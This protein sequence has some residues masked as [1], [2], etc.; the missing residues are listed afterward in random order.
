MNDR[1]F[2]FKH[3]SKQLTFTGRSR[4]AD[5]TALFCPELSLGLDAGENFFGSL[6]THA[7]VVFTHCHAD[8]SFGAS[9]CVSRRRQPRFFIPISQAQLLDAFLLNSQQLTNGAVFADPTVDY[10]CNHVT[11]GVQAGE[12]HDLSATVSFQVFE[13]VHSVP[14]V[15]YGFFERKKRLSP[16][17]AGLS[18]P[19]IAALR[20]SGVDVTHTVNDKLFAFLGDTTHA[21]LINNPELLEFPVVIVECS[22]IDDVDVE[23]A[24]KT[25]HMHWQHLKPIVQAHAATTFVL[26][27]FSLRYN[28]A[29][30]H[31]F[32]EAEAMPNVVVFLAK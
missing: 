20:K 5:V 27:H 16:Q 13:M 7:A 2:T 23:Q 24:A 25:K 3:P 4:A 29:H 30:I 22:F 17:Y 31:A 14:C 1:N 28:A 8:H 6:G 26:I 9:R 12:L 15:G 19:E 32:F 10:E 11:V 18:G 21:A